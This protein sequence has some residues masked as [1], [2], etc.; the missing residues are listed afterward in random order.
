MRNYCKR[1]ILFYNIGWIYKLHETTAWYH[2]HFDIA[3]YFNNIAHPVLL[4]TLCQKRAPLPMVKWVNSFLS[5]QQTAMCLDRRQGDLLPTETGIPQGSPILPPLSSIYTASLS[6]KINQGMDPT[7][8]DP[9]LAGRAHRGKATLT[10][11]ILYVDDGKLTVGSDGI[12]THVLLL[13]HVYQIVEA[14]M[15]EHRLRIDPAKSELIH[16]TW[17][18]GDHKSIN[19]QPPA[20]NTPVMVPATTT[21]PEIVTAPAKMVKW[22]GVTF[23]TKL[24]FLSH[25]KNVST[26]VT[27]AVNSFSMLRNSIRGLHQVYHHHLIQGVILPMMLY[28]SAA[29]W[30]GQKTQ[31]NIIEKVQNKGLRYITGVFHTTPTYVMQIEAAI[32]PIALTLDYIVERKANAAQ[33]FSTRHPVTHHLP[34]QH[35]S[36]NIQESNG[37]PFPEPHK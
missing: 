15:A 29:W 16:H 22:L 37:L 7:Q 18:N 24:T 14:W 13:A 17:C 32:P 26:Q 34:A 8:L 20:I 11:M 5:D 23:D 28:V 33:H 6:E 30:N 27:N 9:N 36:N 35:R 25:L 19:D 31:T 2:L 4:A 21:H 12:T 10:N 3:G 1:C